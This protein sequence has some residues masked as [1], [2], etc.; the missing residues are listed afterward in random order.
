MAK[1]NKL[2]YG[3]YFDYYSSLLTKQ[4]SEVM[5]MFYQDDMSLSEIAEVY[6]ISRQAVAIVIKRSEKLLLHY[7]EK[8]KLFEKNK[9]IFDFLD[10]QKGIKEEAKTVIKKILEE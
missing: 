8:L 9:R 4:Q 10:S 7:E 1:E 3:I 6:N 5:S 2:I